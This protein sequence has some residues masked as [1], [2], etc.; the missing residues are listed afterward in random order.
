MLTLGCEETLRTSASNCTVTDQFSRVAVV[1]HIFFDDAFEV[2]DDNDDESQVNHFV[3]L[4]C[5]VIDEAASAVHQTTIKLRPPKL[6]DTPYGGKLIWTFPGGTKMYIHLKDKSKIRHRKRWSQ[7]MYMYY[8]LGFQLMDLPIDVTRK[9]TLAENTYLLT[10]DG[11]IDF[12]P[13]AVQLLV[14]L[15]KKNKGLG[16][17]CGR[18]HPVGSG[19]FQKCG[20]HLYLTVTTLSITIRLLRPIGTN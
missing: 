4:M 18:I 2:S 19:T 1:A 12:K 20:F 16:A 14:D 7:V 9:E 13:S 6:I 15:M 5:G 3:R 17:T 10:L 11:D 8:L